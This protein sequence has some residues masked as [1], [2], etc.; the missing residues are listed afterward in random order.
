MREGGEFL[1]FFAEH[2]QRNSLW[3]LAFGI[4]S[5]YCMTVILPLFAFNLATESR[6]VLKKITIYCEKSVNMLA[7][8]HNVFTSRYSSCALANK[9]E[10]KRRITLLENCDPETK[11]IDTEKTWIWLKYL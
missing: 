3:K 5:L 1:T 7:K 8:I 9:V 2:F 6:T 11:C 10:E 4:V